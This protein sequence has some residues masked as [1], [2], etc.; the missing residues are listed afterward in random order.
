[1]QQAGMTP[2][3]IT[4]TAVLSACSRA[5]LV[6]EGLQY[7]EHM[8][9]N[10]QITPSVEHYAC[11]VDLLGR[12]GRLNEAH[13]FIENMPLKPSAS[14]WGALLGACRVY[15]NIELAEQASQY[16]FELEPANTGNYVLLSNIYAAA[17]RQ[18]DVAKVRTMMA[19]KGL[20]NRPGCSWIEVKHRMHAFLAGDKSH[21]QREEIYATLK[22]LTKKMEAAGYVPD[23]NF[24]LRDVQEEDKEQILCSHSERLA[25]AF[26]LIN[27][28]HGTPIRI[29]KNLRVCGD[30]H[31]A[32][33]LISKI[34]E[35]EIVVRDSSRFHNFKDG[36]CSCGDYW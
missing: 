21:P 13:N 11:V 4:F 6:N 15:L 9:Q 2:D 36:I 27:T 12:S 33:K 35:R 26:G 22:N 1:M 16:L 17:G 28:S 5:G 23:I 3:S 25:I 20:K 32:T 24:V 8:R 29:I 18:D 34:V 7:F 10:Y 31:I 30:C 14:V 19:D